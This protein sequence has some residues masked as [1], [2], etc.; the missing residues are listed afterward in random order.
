MFKAWRE[1][2]G[3]WRKDP[4][5]QPGID[6]LLE[7]LMAS[8]IDLDAKLDAIKAGVDAVKAELAALKN[9]PPAL[10]TQEQIDALAAKEDAIQAAL[11]A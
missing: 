2:H 6:L 10:A 11:N 5:L 3:K 8:V 7:V 9:Q 1:R 4:K